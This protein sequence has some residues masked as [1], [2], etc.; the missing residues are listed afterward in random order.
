MNILKKDIKIICQGFTGQSATYHSMLSINY[1]SNIVCGVTPGKGGTSHL[2]RPVF[3]SMLEAVKKTK[4]NTS[5][6]FVP[7]RYCKDSIIEAINAKIKIIVCITEG[8]PILDMLYIKNL[9]KNKNITF[10][11]PNSPGFVIPNKCRVGIMPCDIHKAGCIGIISRSGTLTYEAIKQTSD[12]GLGQS[13]SIG[14]G[15]DPI[16]GVNFIDII[17][18]LNKDENTKII[19]MIGEIGGTAEEEAAIY[20]KKYVNK[21]VLAYI[22]GIHAPIGKKMGHAGA[23]IEGN[24]GSAQNKIKILEKHGITIINSL[25]D[26][27]KKILEKYKE[28]YFKKVG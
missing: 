10:I 14:I 28:Y 20:I 1:G 6:I 4:G 8:I 19:V 7:S 26:I 11:G 15:G 25:V 16:T 2:N 5:L 22:A 9:I 27:G 17:K 13:L 18:I 12:I 21:P 3:N 23:I 24:K